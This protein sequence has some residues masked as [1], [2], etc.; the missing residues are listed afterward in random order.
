MEMLRLVGCSWLALLKGIRS[1]RRYCKGSSCVMW[2]PGLYS[3]DLNTC[4][5]SIINSGNLC[6]SLGFEFPFY[7]ANSS[8]L[9]HVLCLQASE[10][11]SCYRSTA[12]SHCLSYLQ[13]RQNNVKIVVFIMVKQVHI[14]EITLEMLYYVYCLQYSIA[15]I[16]VY[17]SS[18]RLEQ[19]QPF[20]SFF[21]SCTKLKVMPT[22][23]CSLCI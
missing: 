9:F 7:K 2:N 12:K 18:A 17:L 14:Y 8:V 11:A 19:I 16:N 10:V 15:V 20:T 3:E 4:F 22:G 13:D 6:T 5:N 1:P 21:S 23:C